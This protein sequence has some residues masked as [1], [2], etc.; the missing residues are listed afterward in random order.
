MGC[1]CNA[2]CAN[3]A[4]PD[5]DS[6]LPYAYLADLALDPVLGPRL[7]GGLVPSGVSAG[8]NIAK[9]GGGPAPGVTQASSPD[10]LAGSYPAIRHDFHF[11]YSTPAMFFQRDRLIDPAMNRELGG[12]LGGPVGNF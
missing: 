11:D 10:P 3:C 5:V 9:P 4:P 12:L 6:R 2:P 8:G 1:G 7:G